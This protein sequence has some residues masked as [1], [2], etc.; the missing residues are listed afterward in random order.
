[1]PANCS[2]CVCV[3]SEVVRQVCVC[4][5][6]LIVMMDAADVVVQVLPT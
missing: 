2:D 6:V 5:R 1:M 4:A 3:Y